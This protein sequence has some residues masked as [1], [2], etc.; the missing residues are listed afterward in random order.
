MLEC[1][2]LSMLIHTTEELDPDDMH[3]IGAYCDEPIRVEAVKEAGHQ[4][5]LTGRSQDMQV[6][7]TDRTERRQVETKPADTDKGCIIRCL[8]FTH[9]A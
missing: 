3:V 8:I 5:H 6:Q 4:A 9:P 1:T 2:C 7:V